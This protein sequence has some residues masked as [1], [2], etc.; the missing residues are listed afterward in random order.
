VRDIRAGIAEHEQLA[1][2]LLRLQYQQGSSDRLRLALEG[3][4]AATAARHIAYYNYVQRARAELIGSLR[5]RAEEVAEVEREARVRRD[6]L[7]QNE[8][9]QASETQ[10]LEKERA[11][12]AA[13][14]ARLAEE[15]AKNRRE[16]GRLKKDEAR[17]THLVEE[18]A[19]RPGREARQARCA[20][21]RHEASRQGRG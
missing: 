19:P 3:K 15:V 20:A 9:D 11:T 18:I 12:R 5:T 6:E 17:L 1:G 2:K 14:V 13:V 21:R 7:A 4:D 10:R 8:T 16:I